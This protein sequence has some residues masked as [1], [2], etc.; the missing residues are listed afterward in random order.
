LAEL[1]CLSNDGIFQGNGT[2]CVNS[3][4]E[5]QVCHD[6]FADAD[7]DGDVDQDDFARFQMCFTGDATGDT[8]G[9]YPPQNCACFD[10]DGDGDVDGT[11]F[12]AF[13]DCASGPGI[14]AD[15]TCDD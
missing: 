6:P 15:T 5:F 12:T 13:Q 3:D 9:T 7:G 1:E 10:T 4:C 11:D 14:P 2:T 8:L